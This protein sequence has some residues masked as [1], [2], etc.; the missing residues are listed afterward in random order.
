MI[1]SQVGPSKAREEGTGLL[2]CRLSRSEPSLPMGAAKIDILGSG[3]LCLLTV[4]G[5]CGLS[6]GDVQQ[7]EGECPGVGR[8]QGRPTRTA[9][10]YRET[11]TVVA[12]K[13]VLSVKPCTTWEPSFR[14]H[15]SR[16]VHTP[17][18]LSKGAINQPPESLLRS[19]VPA[20]EIQASVD[21]AG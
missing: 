14:S 5:S 9:A 19:L 15:Q 4:Q 11:V 16:S 17:V 18:T 20:G 6:C 3:L 1:L 12:V 8:R 21:T 2:S 10:A 13:S 7:G